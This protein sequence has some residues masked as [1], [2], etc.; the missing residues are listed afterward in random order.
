RGLRLNDEII[1]MNDLSFKEDTH[2]R[3]CKYLE[4]RNQWESIK[5]TVER[6][7]EKL[8]FILKKRPV[9]ELLERKE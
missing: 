7:G 4:S 5:L 6:K 3:Y 9:M 2:N 8:E 1:T